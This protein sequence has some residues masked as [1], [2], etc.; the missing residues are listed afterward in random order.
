M[1]YAIAAEHDVTWYLL[2]W[3]SRAP[4]QLPL[5][6]NPIPAEPRTRNIYDRNP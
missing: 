2:L 1:H 5:E 3:V 4:S 6:I